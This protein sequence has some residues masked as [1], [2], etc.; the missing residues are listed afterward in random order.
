MVPGNYK[1][2][3]L[4]TT[5]WLMH[6]TTEREN[7]VIVNPNA[8]RRRGIKD[9]DRISGLLQREG[10]KFNAV[11]TGFPGHA[12]DLA[13]SRIE[14]G[15]RD[16]IVVGGD[17]TMNE[18]I[19]G[20]FRQKRYPTS[21]VKVGMITVGTGNDWGRMFDIPLGYGDA[22]AV[23]KKNHSF[24]QDAGVVKYFHGETET[25]RYF[26][27]IAGIGFDALVTSRSNK[28]KS[29]GK[30]GSFTYLKTLL[31]SLLKYRHTRTRIRIDDTVIK[32]EIFNI[33][34]GICKYNGGGMIQLPDAIPNDGLFDVTVINKIRKHDVILNIKRL[35]NGTIGSM[36][37]V[38]TFRGKSISI[39]SEPLI[40]L[41]TDGESLGHS[42][43][44][45]EIIP[46]SI[47]VIIGEPRRH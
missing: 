12:I 41:E 29:E 10:I 25:D 24:V 26:V 47:R 22:I 11:F 46:A 40:H 45:F 14:S 20:I 1:F 18:V 23:I 36:P 21:E 37:M 27:N 32:N 7:L 9:W 35:Y 44:T 42:P 28:L 6:H 30:A 19:N 5:H 16:L 43:F 4:L 39:E 13:A 3:S 31:T 8:G 38:Q 33:S 2:V 17:G 34:I 15:Y